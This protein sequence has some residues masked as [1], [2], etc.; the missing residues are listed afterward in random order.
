MS[1]EFD[2]ETLREIANITGGEYFR[3]TDNTSLES[4]YQQIDKLEKSKIRAREYHYSTKTEH[5]APFLIAAVI[6]L[7][8]QILLRFFVLRSITE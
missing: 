6:C 5:F 4:I 3:A 1:S 8:L 7:L 2:E